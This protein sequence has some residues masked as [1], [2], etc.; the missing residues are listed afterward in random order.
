MAKVLLEQEQ[1]V[2]LIEPMLAHLGADLTFTI[3]VDGEPSN[4]MILLGSLFA[5]LDLAGGDPKA[6]L[7]AG[8]QAAKGMDLPLDKLKA[9]DGGYDLFIPPIVLIRFR[10]D[11][12]A[13]SIAYGR[14]A[15]PDPESRLAK[16]AKVKLRRGSSMRQK[17]PYDVEDVGKVLLRLKSVLYCSAMAWETWVGHPIRSP[18]DMGDSNLP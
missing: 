11:D 4:P 16:L 3:G 13:L 8:I 17:W 2:R 7:A 18:L 1:R 6:A 5:R 10:T 15:V 9:V 12:N 14:E